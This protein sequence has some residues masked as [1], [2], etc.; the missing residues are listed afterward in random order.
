[1]KLKTTLLIV[2]FLAAATTS[3]RAHH[4]FAAEFDGSKAIRVTGS[5]TKIEW[6]NPHTYFYIE[7][8]DSTGKI[9]TWGCEAASPGALSRRGFKR[10]DLKIGDT[11]VIDGYP[12]K[13]GS[14]LMDARRITLADGRIVSGGSAGD[15]GPVGGQQAQ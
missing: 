15:G 13:D 4:A 7:F 3:L 1:M 12:A 2:S 10:A 8:K 6:A 5:L 9:V 11:I 14:R